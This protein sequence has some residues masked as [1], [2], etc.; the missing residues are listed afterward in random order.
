MGRRYQRIILRR[1]LRATL[2]DGLLILL[3]GVLIG[4]GMSRLVDEPSDTAFNPSEASSGFSIVNPNYDVSDADP[5]RIEQVTFEVV[6]TDGVTPG[7]VAV[8]L[9]RGSN[10]WYG[11]SSRDGVVWECPIPHVPVIQVDDLAIL[12]G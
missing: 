7:Q 9:V 1:R 2:L 12:F 5:P 10:D 8:Q 4:N 11:C 6:A 3:L